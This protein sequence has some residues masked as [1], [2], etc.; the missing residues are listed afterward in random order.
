MLYSWWVVTTAVIGVSFKRSMLGLYFTLDAVKRN[1]R[2]QTKSLK[3]EV[4]IAGEK[5]QKIEDHHSLE[6]VEDN[7]DKQENKE[8]ETEHVLQTGNKIYKEYDDK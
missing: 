2:Q 8:K 3:T 5:G 6:L 7:K 4:D 1:S